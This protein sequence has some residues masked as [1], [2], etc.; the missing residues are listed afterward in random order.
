MSLI[1]IKLFWS[2]CVEGKLYRACVSTYYGA[3]ICAMKVKNMRNFEK[4]PDDEL[5]LYVWSVL[6]IPPN[7]RWEPC[8]FNRNALMAAVRPSC[9]YK[10][11]VSGWCGM[12]GQ[13]EIVWA[14][15]WRS[16]DWPVGCGVQMGLRQMQD[17][18]GK[19]C[20]VDLFRKGHWTGICGR[21]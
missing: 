13:I 17:D 19:V 4:M 3:N 21:V 11:W 18:L 20:E 2:N 15:I 12:V 8:Q 1:C 9:P 5:V 7:E 14:R 6:G 16:L 10:G